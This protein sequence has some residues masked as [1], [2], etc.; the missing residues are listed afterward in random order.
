[1]DATLVG[2]LHPGMH[3]LVNV[4]TYP[5]NGFRLHHRLHHH[6]VVSLLRQE[7]RREQTLTE[8]GLPDHH[9]A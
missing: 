8:A 5:R 9:C 4:L 7:H 3:L 2:R 6:Q 1:M